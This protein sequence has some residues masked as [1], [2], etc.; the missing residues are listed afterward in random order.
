M[1]YYVISLAI[2]TL[3]VNQVSA[4]DKRETAETTKQFKTLVMESAPY[5]PKSL[6]EQFISCPI[7][8]TKG[9]VKPNYFC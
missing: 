9:I 4:N 8:T 2:F 7:N 1:R 3:L 6:N 5:L